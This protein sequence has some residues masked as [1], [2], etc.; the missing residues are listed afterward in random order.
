MRMF[1]QLV[2][3][4]A[5][6]GLV[7]TAMGQTG[8]RVGQYPDV[9]V[10]SCGGSYDGGTMGNYGS[11]SG[12]ASYA[13]GSDSCNIG[14]NGAIWIS[15]N[16]QHPVIGGEVYRLF[17]GRFEQVGMSW[18]K[19]GFC[20][21]D[22]CSTGA[23]S[24]STQGCINI[25]GV[26]AGTTG[27]VTDYNDGPTG[28]CDWLGSGRATDTYGS[29]LNGSQGYLGPRSEVNAWSG[30]YPYPYVRQGSN[31]SSCL[32]KRLLIRQ[33]D[34]DPANY[35][36]YNATTNPQGA[37]YFAEVVY[38]VTDEWPTERYNNYTH[39][40]LSVDTTLTTPSGGCGGTLFALNF[41]TGAG[42]LSVPF[43]PAIYEWKTI[44]PTVT[45][46]TLDSPNDGRF[47]VGAKVTNIGTGQWQYEYAVF[48]LDAD[49][50]AGAFSV[51]KSSNS[52]LQ[53]SNLG[54]HA[55]E[56][57]SGEPYS[58]KPWDMN[59]LGNSVKFSTDSYAS[60][61]NANALRW[62]TLYN[63]RFTAN[64]P[65]KTDANSKIH[66]DL[67]KPGVQVTDANFIEVGNVPVPGD[68]PSCA[69]DFNSSGTLDSQDIFDFLSAWFSGD[70]R[71]DFNHVDG[72][73]SQDIFDFLNAWFVG[74]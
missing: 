58:A 6:V 29:G 30:V 34:L 54:F 50:S 18:L 22:S 57:H 47:V 32:N 68:P 51:P 3:A 15:G 72:L 63:F 28:G 45:I 39:R 11:A 19:H 23:N 9:I 38:I 16:N 5:L 48:N 13:I 37:Q 46:V 2:G 73:N 20:A 43:K 65:P 74:C 67:F 69:A 12:W 71:A 21:A 49:R 1:A 17:N 61:A 42:M 52:A 25:G 59:V 44:D 36:R 35:P 10:S 26:A 62:S 41:T 55:P 27:C 70:P 60:N 31:P 56:Y 66:I 40:R 7:G 24:G 64:Q 53:I 8:P 4:A 14:L 33:T